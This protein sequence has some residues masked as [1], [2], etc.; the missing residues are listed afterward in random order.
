MSVEMPA[1]LFDPDLSERLETRIETILSEMTLAEKIGQMRQ[2]DAAAA[3]S[4]PAIIEAVRRGEIGSIINLVD[5]DQIIRLQTAARRESR[6]Q[7][8]LL[9]A[10]DVIHG[11]ETIFPIPL[12]QAA[13]W[14]PDLVRQASRISAQEASAVG[15]NWTFAPML[16]VSRDARWGRI[17]ESFG[18]DPFLTSTFGVAMIEGLQGRDLSAPGALAAC[19]KHF[20]GYG[21]SEGGRD[22]SATNIPENELHNTYLPPFLAAVRAGAVSVMS[23]FSDLDGVPATANTHLLRDVLRTDWGFDGVLI[24]D[25]NAVHELVIHGFVETDAEAAAAAINAGVDIEMNGPAYADSIGQLLADNRITLDQI[26]TMVARILRLKAALGLFD[27]APDAFLDAALPEADPIVTARELA[28]QST[29]LLKNTGAVLPLNAEHLKSVA[30]L[31]PLA[32]AAAE[33]LG[34]WVFD[35]DPQRA[36]TPLQALKDASAGR[37]EVRHLAVL[38]NTRDHATTDF[39]QAC[40][41]A[42]DSDVSIVCIGEDAILSGEAHCRARLDLP[43]AQQ[44]LLEAVHAQG[45]P[46]VVIVMAGRP[47]ALTTVLPF[48]DALLYAWHPGT[49]GGPALADLLLGAVSP[50]GRLPVSFVRS[51]GQIPIHYNRKNTGRPAT[52]DSIL[53][54]DDIPADARQTSFGMTAFHLD[55]GFT[56]LFPFG[57]GL[58]YGRFDYGPATTSAPA[59]TE[60]ESLEVWASVTNTGALPATETVQLYVRDLVG[61]VTRPI[62]ELK[63]FRRIH[64]QPGETAEV[65]FTLTPADLTFYTRQRQMACE[66]GT[67]EVWIA[68]DAHAGAPARFD[69]LAG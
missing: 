29:V 66:P 32:D 23:S 67:F 49:M 22:Y 51:V 2:I 36:V 48:A 26:D 57:F 24:S 42:R 59:I 6:M 47:L 11:F 34:T 4:E 18:E 3:A 55:D 14:N 15:V 50:S 56:P 27:K 46:V 61:S 5:P 41:L 28:R 19:A 64:L 17:A 43:G 1:V 58:S 9:V 52:E 62:R 37:F 20:V 8:P 69:L 38:A 16:D 65:R 10:R 21:A 39:E 53:L 63:G 54:I 45:K 33:Q 12:G 35:G 31:G 60:G 40:A 44:A 7:I 13:S 30:L 68:P 25:W